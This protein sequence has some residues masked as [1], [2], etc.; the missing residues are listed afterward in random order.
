MIGSL[1][2]P[3]SLKD[4]AALVPKNKS[5]VL[6]LVS[7]KTA[8]LEHEDALRRRLDEASRDVPLDRLGLSTQCGFASVAGGNAIGVWGA[9]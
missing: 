7:S 1:L 2:R 9:S 4:A 3:R 6:G 8:A 5:V